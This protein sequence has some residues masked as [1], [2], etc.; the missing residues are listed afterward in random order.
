VIRGVILVDGV[1][2]D[3]SPGKYAQ[4]IRYSLATGVIEG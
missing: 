4:Q 1:G 2:P 3:P